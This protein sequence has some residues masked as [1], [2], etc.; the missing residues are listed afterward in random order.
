MLYLVVL[1]ASSWVGGRAL[2]EFHVSPR[3]LMAS[4]SVV[5]LGSGGVWWWLRRDP[6]RSRR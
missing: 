4:L 1:G 5:L 2:D 6:L 3:A